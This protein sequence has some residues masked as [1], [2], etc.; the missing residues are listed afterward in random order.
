MQ[1]GQEF[2]HILLT[3]HAFGKGRAYYRAGTL[4]E[5]SAVALVRQTLEAAGVAVGATMPRNVNRFERDGK[6]VYLNHTS[7]VRTV[8]GQDRPLAPYEVRVV[9][10]T[11]GK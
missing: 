8:P 5:Q 9:E 1:T 7:A 3:R 11:H 6:A 2:I 10:L 4:D